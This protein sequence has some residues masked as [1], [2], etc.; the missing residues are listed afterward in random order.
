MTNRLKKS[1]ILGGACTFGAFLGGYVG[2]GK[3]LG[4]IPF[5]LSFSLTTFVAFMIYGRPNKTDE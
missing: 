4:F 2:D 1:F 3:I 5:L